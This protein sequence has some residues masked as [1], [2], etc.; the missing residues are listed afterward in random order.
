MKI[1]FFLV[2]LLM[3]LASIA[4]VSAWNEARVSWAAPT[5]CVDGSAISNCPVTGYIIESA[6]TPAAA[7]WAQAATVTASTTSRL[8]TG[9]VAGQHCYRVRA[10]ATSG[11]SDPSSVVCKTISA[12]VPS[13]P[14]LVTVETVAMSIRADWE[15]LAFVPSAAVGSVALGVACDSARSLAGGWYAIPTTSVRW[16]GSNRP[17]NVVARCASGG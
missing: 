16:S 1:R 4:Q 9:L 6:S 14:T 15:R 7:T 2:L 3:P 8:F 11:N 10:Q 12:P 17:A 13:P 5:T